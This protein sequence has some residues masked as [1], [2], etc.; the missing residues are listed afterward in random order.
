MQDAAACMKVPAA[1]TV[2]GMD[3]LIV[4]AMVFFD[5]RALNAIG[6]H[7]VLCKHIRTFAFMLQYL[8]FEWT[9]AQGKPCRVEASCNYS[10][11]KELDGIWNCPISK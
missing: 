1:V 6:S 7:A 4:F 9:L 5:T 3:F 2:C 10:P 11:P 8:H